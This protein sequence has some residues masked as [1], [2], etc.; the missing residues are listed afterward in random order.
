MNK[1][2]IAWTQKPQPQS[3]TTVEMWWLG[4]KCKMSQVTDVAE[5]EN[6][7]QV[8]DQVINMEPELGLGHFVQCCT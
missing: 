8:I 6:E 1:T 2:Q 4:L 5:K 7:E 3:F